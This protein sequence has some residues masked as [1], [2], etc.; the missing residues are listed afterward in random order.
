MD[1]GFFSE[2]NINDFMK[3]HHKFLIGA[4]CNLKLV[5]KYLDQV[6]GESF[7]DWKNF[8]ED[9]GLY[10]KTFTTQW[11]IILRRRLAQEKQ[12]TARNEF[13]CTSTSI[14]SAVSMNNSVSRIGS[15]ISSR[16]SRL[17]SVLPATKRN[18]QDILF[19]TRC[20]SAACLLFR[21]KKP[22]ANGRRISATLP[23]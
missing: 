23:Y 17:G 10:A 21:R 15:C 22:S 5:R 2:R 14:H 1:R 7:T 13:T 12:S 4:R 6:R 9:V 20:R 18:T 19:A 8:N 16:S 3:H 11:G